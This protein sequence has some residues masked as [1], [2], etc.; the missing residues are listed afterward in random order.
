MSGLTYGSPEAARANQSKVG[1]SDLARC[2]AALEVDLGEEHLQDEITALCEAQR[3]RRKRQPVPEPLA[4]PAMQEEGPP[5]PRQR[6]RFAGP[7]EEL[8]MVP[9][10]CDA[11]YP[12]E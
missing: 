2:P 5:Q 8:R 10:N 12:H 1:M 4:M 11:E 6:L 7:P 9:A 3:S